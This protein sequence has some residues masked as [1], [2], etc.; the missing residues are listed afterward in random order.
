M[1]ERKFKN[2]KP[3][4]SSIEFIRAKALFEAE[5]DGE[6]LQGTFLEATPNPLDERKSDYKFETED[7]EIKVINGAGNLGFSMKFVDVG[8]YVRV[9]YH[10]KQE[11]SKGPM[12]GKLA[13]NFSV[14]REEG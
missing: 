9:N 8:E 14:E 1:T 10:G 12:K 5:L 13:H 6:V 11:I 7:G 2:V 3:E 4:G